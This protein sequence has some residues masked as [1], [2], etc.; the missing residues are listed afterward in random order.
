MHGACQPRTHPSKNGNTVFVFPALSRC[1]PNVGH[2]PRTYTASAAPVATTCAVAELLELPLLAGS[3]DR[4]DPDAVDDE[5]S[6]AEDSLDA[7]GAVVAMMIESLSE[8]DP[9]PGADADADTGA[10]VVA[11]GASVVGVSV[12]VAVTVDPPVLPLL[13]LE[14]VLV[15]PPHPPTDFSRSVLELVPLASSQSGRSCASWRMTATHASLSQDHQIITDHG[16]T[17]AYWE[18]ASVLA[19]ATYRSSVCCV[20]ASEHVAARAVA[21]SSAARTAAMIPPRHM[22]PFTCRV[23]WTM[24]RR[25]T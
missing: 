3:P 15:P 25:S 23:D 10:S 7:G 8:D 18:H 13:M 11:V 16:S 4:S 22:L 24:E 12:G 1:R 5:D 2:A 21:P 14:L 9:D 19:A 17:D 20:S 6:D